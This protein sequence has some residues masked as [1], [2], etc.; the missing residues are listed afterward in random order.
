MLPVNFSIL[1]AY[2]RGIARIEMSVVADIAVIE[3]IPTGGDSKEPGRF[4]HFYIFG[5]GTIHCLSK[6]LI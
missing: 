4:V 3:G 2:F 1:Y 5:D 6:T